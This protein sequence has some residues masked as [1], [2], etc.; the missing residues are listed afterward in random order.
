LNFNEGG[1]Y[2]VTVS[3]HGTAIQHMSAPDA[4]ED[5]SVSLVIQKIGYDGNRIGHPYQIEKYE[6]FAFRP[7]EELWE[8]MT[9]PRYR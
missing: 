8:Y 3:A 9:T 4:E 7:F 5:G 1:Y 6:D 2:S